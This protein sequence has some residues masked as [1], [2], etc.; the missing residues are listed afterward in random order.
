VIEVPRSFLDEIGAEGW[1]PLEGDANE[2]RE[3]VAARYVE[4]RGAR[5]TGP[6]VMALRT[7][8][9]EA[10]TLYLEGADAAATIVASAAELSVDLIVL[11]ATKR[12]FAENHWESVTSRIIR[13]ADR[14]VLVVPS[15]HRDDTGELD[16]PTSEF[17]VG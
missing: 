8:E 10:E 14:P 16:L 7:S 12:L 3:D 17:Q 15:P 9:I 4:E 6:V 5:I 13:E 11:G 1:H 2:P